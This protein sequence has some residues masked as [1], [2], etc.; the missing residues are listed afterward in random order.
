LRLKSSVLSAFPV[1]FFSIFSNCSCTSA[2]IPES[3]ALIFANNSSVKSFLDKPY[4]SFLSTFLD[5]SIVSTK[6]KSFI[7]SL[8]FVGISV[9]FAFSPN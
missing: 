6:F 9:L 2:V 1:K 4:P 8:I 3:L 7:N 5:S